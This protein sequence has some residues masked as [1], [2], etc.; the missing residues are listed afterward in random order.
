MQND[1]TSPFRVLYL[2]EQFATFC[3]NWYT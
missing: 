1:Y 2:E 3:H